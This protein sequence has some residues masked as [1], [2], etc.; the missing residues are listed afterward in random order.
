MYLQQEQ[1]QFIPIMVH[2]AHHSTG[3][4]KQMVWNGFYMRSNTEQKWATESLRKPVEITMVQLK[5]CNGS[6]V[7]YSVNFE[8]L[9]LALFANS[10]KF[11]NQY[12]IFQLHI[13]KIDESRKTKLWHKCNLKFSQDI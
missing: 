2:V 4:I 12:L 13:G 10:R 9:E 6:S 11:H 8:F 7:F 3:Q 5:N 1:E